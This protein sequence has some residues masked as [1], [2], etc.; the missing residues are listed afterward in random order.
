MISSSAKC[1]WFA[2]NFLLNEEAGSQQINLY[3]FENNVSRVKVKVMG[4]SQKSILYL[5]QQDIQYP[6]K[7]YDTDS[8]GKNQEIQEISDSYKLTNYVVVLF[9][10]VDV[11]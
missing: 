6:A 7:F 10:I 8:R 5:T 4:I 3:Q 11:T 1:L 2:G 9:V